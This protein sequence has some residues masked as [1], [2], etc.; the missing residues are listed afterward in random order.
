MST[1]YE[2]W[3]TTSTSEKRIMQAGKRGVKK[4]IQRHFRVGHLSN[5]LPT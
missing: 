4:G 2:G 5:Q 1:N 3:Q